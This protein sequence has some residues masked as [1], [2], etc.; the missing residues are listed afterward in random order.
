M[1]DRERMAIYPEDIYVATDKGQE[2]LR[3]GSTTLTPAELEILVLMDAKLTAKQIWDKLPHLEEWEIG[4]LIPKLIREGYAQMATFE[5]QDNLDFSYFFDADKTVPSAEMLAQAHKEAESGAPEL[6]REGYYVSITRRHAGL[7]PR[8]PKVKPVVLAIED[9][10]GVSM[11]LT[12]V[13]KME[14]YEPRTA[15]NRAEVLAA[16]R[17]LPSPDLVLLDIHLP[18]ANGFE[19]L[20]RMKQHPVLKAIPVIML[21]GEATRESVAKGLADG[22]DGYMT[23]PFDVAILRKGIRN[24]LGL[25]P[26]A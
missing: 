2:E 17:H 20:E 4:S 23:K 16:L 14:G 8:D 12:Q 25:A 6:A 24:V 5:D 3:R 15:K 10:P 21:T 7:L 19:I 22:A 26:A 18:D 13:L 11:L 1:S 9:D